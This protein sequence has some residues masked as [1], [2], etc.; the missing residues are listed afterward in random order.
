M[1]HRAGLP[2]AYNVDENAHF[3]PRAI[4]LFGHG[5]NPHYYVNPPAYTYVL[6][7]VLRGLAFGGRDGVAHAFATDPRGRLRRRAA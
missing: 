1:G 6:H 2:Y 7:V 4:G 5:C 3:V